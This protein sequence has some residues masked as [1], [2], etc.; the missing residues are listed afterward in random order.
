M[1]QC[2]VASLHFWGRHV[3]GIRALY[4]AEGPSIRCKWGFR[5]LQ[6]GL[7]Y[8]INGAYA[9]YEKGVSGGRSGL[10]LLLQQVGGGGTGM[11]LHEFLCLSGERSLEEGG[12]E[13]TVDHPHDAPHVDVALLLLACFKVLHGIV[14]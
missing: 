8:A 6:M 2:N 1:F 12:A 10:Q 11:L 7:P 4:D 13:G 14:A 3:T 9:W 5:T